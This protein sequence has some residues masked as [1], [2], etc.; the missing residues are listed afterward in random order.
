M[1]KRNAQ[2]WF[3]L[4][5]YHSSLKHVR[6]AIEAYKKAIEKNPKYY[7]A[8]TNLAAEYFQLKEYQK[9]MECCKEAIKANQHDKHAWLT[10]AAN[11]FQMD[12]DGRS[13]FCFHRASVLGNKKAEKFLKNAEKLHDK[14]LKAEIVNV[15]GEILKKPE[16]KEK[17]K[18]PQTRRPY[19]PKIPDIHDKD[20]IEKLSGFLLEIGNDLI[21]KT[22]G[23]I[24]ILELYSLIK[25]EYPSFEGDADDLLK[26]L[27]SLEEKNLIE[28]VKLVENSNIKMV[29]F[30]PE[31]LTEDIKEIIALAEKYAY[32]TKELIISETSW[33]SYRVD[34]IMRFLEVK[35]IAR[36]T[37]S[38]REGK[39][40]YFPGANLKF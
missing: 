27:A 36:K 35:K 14:L 5:K 3:E 11:Y 32:L 9:S 7:Q 18:V 16:K 4:G 26:S 30:I 15:E 39:K 1:S 38:F 19:R 12:D 40:W 2:E 25:S 28:G 33:E 17:E 10:L 8:W 34:R 31:D 24:S 21:I 29:E 22:G 20:Y 23:M 37:E 13:L 6:S